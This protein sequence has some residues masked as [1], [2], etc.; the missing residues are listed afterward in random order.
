MN[1]PISTAFREKV[2]SALQRTGIPVALAPQMS[3][4]T[5]DNLLAYVSM[6]A[7]S[8][9]EGLRADISR[10]F[11]WCF[12]NGVDGTDPLA[13]DIRDFVC[14]FE[15]GR[16]P[17]TVKRMIMNIGVLIAAIYGRDNP[18]HSKIVRAEL[19]RLYRDAAEP[20]KQALAIRQKGDVADFN[21]PALPFSIERMVDALAPID[22]LTSLRAQLILS[23]AGDTGRRHGEYIAANFGH[24]SEAA[25]GTGTFLIP[26]SKTDQE[27]TGIVR[28]T[29]RRTMRILKT[30][31][32]MRVAAGDV[33][34]PT[35]PL[36][37]MVS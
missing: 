7:K 3:K 10:W 35:T 33:I 13:S 25:D 36:F 8:T 23:L 31:R 16:K 20:S 2:E 14:V 34:D 30:W 12:V 1:A 6:S 37:V 26:Q 5:T 11:T 27:G 21:E 22:T 18:T 15:A 4:N 9:L 19:R 17:P 32:E 24:I 29:S 28:F